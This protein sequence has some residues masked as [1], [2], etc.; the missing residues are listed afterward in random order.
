MSIIYRYYV[1]GQCEEHFLNSFKSGKNPKFKPGKVEVFNI[2]TQKITPMR[3]INFSAGTT[4]VLVYDTDK[5]PTEIFENNLKQLKNN[6]KISKIIH[7]QSV[8]NFEEEIV[9]SS[10]VKCIN[11]VFNTIGIIEFKKKFISANIE[12]KMKTINFDFKKI[13]SRKS[14]LEEFKKYPQGGNKIKE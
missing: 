6:K 13:W 1:E 14:K 4:L 3:L 2:M 11:E 7:V 8:K 12:N 10:N 5:S 9:Y